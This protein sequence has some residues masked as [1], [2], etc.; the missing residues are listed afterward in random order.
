MIT[1]IKENKTTTKEEKD[2]SNKSHYQILSAECYYDV[3]V[4]EKIVY[5]EKLHDKEEIF[6]ANDAILGILTE[7]FTSD[8]IQFFKI[9]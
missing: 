8:E 7:H 3:R 4:T 2:W 1:G 6:A 5:G 9:I